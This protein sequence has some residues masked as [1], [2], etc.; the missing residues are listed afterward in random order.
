MKRVALTLVV[1]LTAIVAVFAV[2]W[3]LPEREKES[4]DKIKVG[5]TIFPIYDMTRKIGGDKIDVVRILPAGASPHTFEL[6]SSKIRE[7]Q[8]SVAVF[9]IGGIDDWVDGVSESLNLEKISLREGINIK[10]YSVMMIGE[11]EEEGLS[12]DPHYWMTMPNAKIMARE[13]MGRISAIDPDN[14]V[15]YSD[16]LANFEREADMA[17]AEIRYILKDVRGGSLI[18]F[19][20]AWNY[21]AEEYGL[22]VAASFEPS[23]GKEPAVAHLKAL[24]DLV[25]KEKI[26]VI[27][28]EPAFSDDLIKSFMND[29]GLKLYVLYPEDSATGEDSYIGTMIANAKIIAAGLSVK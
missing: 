11:E 5:A 9:K 19:H 16:N 20:G 18:A 15:Y 6:T 14:A 21:F 13:I 8:G 27:F 12:G 3:I 26:K 1:F 7:L 22:K 10:N 4:S 24:S 28:S 2:L 23:P 29:L 25:V 17:D